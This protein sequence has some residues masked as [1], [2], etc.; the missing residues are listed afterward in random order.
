MVK[1][2]LVFIFFFRFEKLPLKYNLSFSQ[3]IQKG[4]QRTILH[5]TRA[6]IAIVKYLDR[7]LNTC[8][9]SYYLILI[10]SAVKEGFES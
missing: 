6:Y 1:A 5:P 8:T 10:S 7:Y 9:Q 4:T 2:H 3:K